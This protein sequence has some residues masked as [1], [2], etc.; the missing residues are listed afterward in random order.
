MIYV[1][2]K[3]S[4]SLWLKGVWDPELSSYVL[5]LTPIAMTIRVCP[6]AFG[7]ELCPANRTQAASEID[8]KVD[9]T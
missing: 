2:V 8:Q 1:H 7:L 3:K 5:F 6:G 9:F 4:P